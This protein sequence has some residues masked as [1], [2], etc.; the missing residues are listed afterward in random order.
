MREA[1]ELLA[2]DFDRLSLYFDSTQREVNQFLTNH[3]CHGGCLLRSGDDEWELPIDN[4]QEVRSE[5]A[6]PKL[7]DGCVLESSK[8]RVEIP[9]FEGPTN[10]GEGGESMQFD[11]M[12][13]EEL[14]EILGQTIKKDEINK[15]ITFLCMLS[16]YT[17]D[18]QMNISSNAPSATGK[19]YVPLKQ[20][21]SS[22]PKT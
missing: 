11:P 12:S 7:N 5:G 22:L 8:G 4:G 14:T 9:R 10:D 15:Q 13:T 19:S 3:A 2:G 20:L 1:L 17:N 21:A 18:S 16:A 6:E